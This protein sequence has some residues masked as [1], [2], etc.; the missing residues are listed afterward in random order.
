LVFVY[1]DPDCFIPERWLRTDKDTETL[2]NLFMP[3]ST[4][5]RNCV[6]QNLAMLELKLVLATLLRRYDFQLHTEVKPK[7][8]M[9]L[10]PSNAMFTMSRRL[11]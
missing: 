2:K 7:S 9:T 1:K 8:F 10:N 5:R 3:F 11:D 6:G 4:G